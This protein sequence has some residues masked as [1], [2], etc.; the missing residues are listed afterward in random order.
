MRI[1]QGHFARPGCE[2]SMMMVVLKRSVG[3]IMRL[4]AASVVPDGQQITSAG[5]VFTKLL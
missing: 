3:G 1:E 4:V 5:H 2:V